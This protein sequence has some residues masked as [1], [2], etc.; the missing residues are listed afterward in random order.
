MPYKRAQK[1]TIVDN[2]RVNKA[3]AITRFYYIYQKCPTIRGLPSITQSVH[4]FCLRVSDPQILIDERKR[5]LKSLSERTQFCAH[6]GAIF[7]HDET[8]KY[9]ERK[10]ETQAGAELL[11]QQVRM[12]PNNLSALIKFCQHFFKH[13]Y[14]KI[15]SFNDL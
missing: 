11:W 3:C 8:G 13:W 4:L 2:F 14:V 7:Y 6:N 9:P 15:S 1:P 10:I 12:H 5:N